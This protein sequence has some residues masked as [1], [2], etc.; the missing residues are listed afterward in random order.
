[1]QLSPYPGVDTEM[2]YKDINGVVFDVSEHDGRQ[3]KR[4][5]AYR[6]GQGSDG[7]ARV[8]RALITVGLAAGLPLE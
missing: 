4:A 6:C 2:K 5:D 8:G 1:M 3:A 7:Q